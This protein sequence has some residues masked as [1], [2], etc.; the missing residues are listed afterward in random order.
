VFED[1]ETLNLLSSAARLF[2]AQGQVRGVI[3]A[4][5]DVTGFN[6]A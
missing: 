2:D 3:G 4:H 1:G 5:V 6:G